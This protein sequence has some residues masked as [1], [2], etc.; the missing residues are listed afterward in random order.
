MC[1]VMVQRKTLTNS[2]S[3]PNDDPDLLHLAP[4]WFLPLFPC[5]MKGEI[6]VSGAEASTNNPPRAPGPALAL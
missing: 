3:E 5:L 6:S 2:L 1:K 4:L